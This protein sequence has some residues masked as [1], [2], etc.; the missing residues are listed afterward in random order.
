MPETK[1]QITIATIR[2][3]CNQI[4]YLAHLLS[5]LQERK[6]GSITE[7]KGNDWVVELSN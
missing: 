4:E 3:P 5:E 6:V 7:L 1:K 2:V